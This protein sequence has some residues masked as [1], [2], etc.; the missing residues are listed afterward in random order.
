[1][2]SV[3]MAPTPQQASVPAESSR[4]QQVLISPARSDTAEVD[5]S[6]KIRAF[7]SLYPLTAPRK[8][9]TPSPKRTTKEE[10]KK[11]TL[12]ASKP[13]PQVAVPRRSPLTNT[14]LDKLRST[15]Y[16]LQNLQL[17]AKTSQFRGPPIL[18]K[19]AWCSVSEYRSLN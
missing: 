9:C 17:A 10:K 13:A 16:S 3:T 11:R 4:H 14:A 1:M 19:T 7:M 5:P 12:E 2:S 18:V 6:F 8:A 15:A